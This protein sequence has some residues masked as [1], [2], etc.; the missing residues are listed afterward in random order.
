MES[1]FFKIFRAGTHTS[2]SGQTITYTTGDLIATASAYSKTA[3]KVPLVLGH[4]PSNGPALGSVTALQVKDGALF[5]VAD[6]SDELVQL[7]KNGRY[8]NVSAAFFAPANVDN[9]Y[10]GVWS[11]RH[12][13]FL[14]AVQPG[15]K[16]L[17]PLEFSDFQDHA[18]IAFSEEGTGTGLNLLPAHFRIFTFHRRA[19]ELKSL[20][21]G[22]SYEDAYRI[23]ETSSPFVSSSST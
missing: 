22:M 8:G 4:P 9:P 20:N 17:G 19:I 21:A 7:V 6:V 11:L 12:V 18:G 3:K 5:A 2:M 15:V 16:G 13:G 23:V 10:P 14:G 1:K